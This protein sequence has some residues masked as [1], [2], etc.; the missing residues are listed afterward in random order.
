[1]EDIAVSLF[2]GKYGGKVVVCTINVAPD[3]TNS[4]F[5][6]EDTDLNLCTHLICINSIWD[7]TISE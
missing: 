7:K 1:M 2:I 6:I 4:Q 5:N 3:S